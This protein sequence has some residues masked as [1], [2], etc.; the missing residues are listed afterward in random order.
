MLLRKPN[1]SI[2]GLKHPPETLQLMMPRQASLTCGLV[3][4]V[5]K[6]K[7]MLWATDKYLQPAWT[8]GGMQENDGI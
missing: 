8:T 6:G 5:G 3:E 7:D 1:T 4:S 2:I